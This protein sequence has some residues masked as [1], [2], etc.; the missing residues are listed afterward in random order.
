MRALHQFI[1]FSTYLFS[2]YYFL[3][4]DIQVK[5]TLLESD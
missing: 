2:I 3:L 1:I 5:Q 4:Q